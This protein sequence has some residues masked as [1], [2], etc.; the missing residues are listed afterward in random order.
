MTLRTIFSVILLAMAP[1]AIAAPQAELDQLTR[2]F[3]VE[4]DDSFCLLR[5]SC[6]GMT[7]LLTG[8]WFPAAGESSQSLVQNDNAKLV[9]LS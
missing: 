6:V 8:S 1:A 3:W 2:Q 4:V 9:F 5:S 7:S